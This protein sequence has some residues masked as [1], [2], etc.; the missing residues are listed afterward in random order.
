MDNKDLADRIELETRK[1]LHS[2]NAE[3][4][5]IFRSCIFFLPETLEVCLQP[6]TDLYGT[7]AIESFRKQLREI[8][9]AVKKEML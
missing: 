5:T 9:Q 3:A 2:K 7:D 6:D 4:F 1:R 8:H